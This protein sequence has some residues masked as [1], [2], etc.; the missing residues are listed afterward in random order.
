MP[1]PRNILNQQH[2]PCF[3]IPFISKGSLD[4]YFPIEQK[5]ILTLGRI[6]EIV[7]IAGIDL[8][9]NDPLA[10]TISERDPIRPAS[11]KGIVTSSK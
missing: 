9:E 5:D 10:E 2:I 11:F 8:P 3:K 1:F 7:V 4:L 6:V